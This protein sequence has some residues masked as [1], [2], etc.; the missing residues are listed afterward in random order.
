MSSGTKGE[1]GIG[2]AR[3]GKVKQGLDCEIPIC[4]IDFSFVGTRRKLY[5]L[6]QMS[7]VSKMTRV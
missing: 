2:R 4:F 1:D 3:E 6:D 5:K 7:R